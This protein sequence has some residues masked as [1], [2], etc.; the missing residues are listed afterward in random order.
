MFDTDE[1]LLHIYGIQYT[2]HTN[3]TTPYPLT[4]PADCVVPIGDICC[5]S[6]A[7]SGRLEE[8]WGSASAAEGGKPVL[9]ADTFD[10]SRFAEGNK[11]ET[12]GDFIGFGH[13]LH[14]CPGKPF[15]L[16]DL[17]VLFR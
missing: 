4:L 13:G 15:A 1:H 14:K 11:V 12:N 7:V 6:T 3:T 9:T 17:K 10:P 5:M 8:T 16:L 2:T